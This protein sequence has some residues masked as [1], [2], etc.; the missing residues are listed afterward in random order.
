MEP[1]QLWQT[2]WSHGPYVPLY[3]FFGGLTA[4]VFI[5]AVGA[6]L[7][8]IKWKRADTLSKLATY[9]ALVVLGLAGFFLT[10]H[11]GKPERGLAFPLFFIDIFNV[12]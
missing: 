4:G 11:L 5:V 12:P 7:L 8:G 9:S 2:K 6:D 10:V 1:I 3:L